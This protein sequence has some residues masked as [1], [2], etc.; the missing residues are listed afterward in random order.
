M[1]QSPSADL[2]WGFDLGDMTDP[3]TYDSLKPAWMS[4]GGE[5]E[6]D[7]MGW[8]ELNTFDPNA[9]TTTPSSCTT[10]CCALVTRKAGP[11]STRSPKILRR[12]NCHHE[13][14]CALYPQ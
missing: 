9:A 8:Q 14:P 11:S 2:Y 3:D 12:R 10:V 7:E 6:D 5:D 4:G 13:H 1:G